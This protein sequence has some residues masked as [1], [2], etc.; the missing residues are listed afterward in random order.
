MLKKAIRSLR[1]SVRVRARSVYPE[2]VLNLC[3]ARGIDFWD[4]TWLSTTELS[5][6]VSRSDLRALRRA[7]EGNDMELSI[8]RTAGVPFFL[9][10]FRR[11]YALLAGLVFCAALL[12]V[13]SFFIWDFAVSG[14]ETVPS[15]KILRALRDEGVHRG[16]F[17]YSFDSQELCNRVLPK[18]KDLCWLTVNVRGCRAYVEVRERVHAPERVN[19]SEATNVVASRAGLVTRVRALDGEKLVLPGTSVQEGQLLISGVVDTGGTE[20]P[21]VA[22]RFLAGKGEVWARTWYELSIRIPLSYEEKIYTGEK[23]RSHA[24]CW[25]ENRIKITA[26]GSSILDGNCDTI[27]N[28][29]SWTLLGIFS[30][31]VTW[32]TETHLF[33][34]THTCTRSRA[35][36]EEIGAQALRSHLASLI[37]EDGS[38]A[39]ERIASA[40]QGQWLLVTLSAECEQQIGKEVPIE[41]SGA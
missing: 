34:E 10:R 28:Q 32:E 31:P 35:E 14:N 7:C 22:T 1:G 39:H 25:G 13:N 4:L 41:I 29:T 27:K 21:S 36:A 30:L 23:N 6:S 16:T 2:R 9:A 26:K 18:L 3:S 5:F 24:L 38:V 19:E 33:Y 8:E 12:T 17:V 40:Q 20:H 15:E 37:G 11:R